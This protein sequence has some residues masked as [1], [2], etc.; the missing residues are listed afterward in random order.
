[1]TESIHVVPFSQ[2]IG[3]EKAIQVLKKAMARERMPHAYLFVGIHG[4]GKTTTALALAQAVNCDAPVEGEACDRCRLCRQILNGNFPDLTVINPD[5]RSIKIEQIREL[6]RAFSFKPVAGRYRVSIVR[7]AELM[8]EEAA[9]SFLKTLEEPP[10][11][12]I[13]ILDVK[14]P[15]DL[16]PT[17]VSR[18]QKVL[19][20][21]IPAP[22][23]EK[24]LQDHMDVDPL[25]ASVLARI[26]QG[27]LARALDL[28]DDEFME[29]RGYYVSQF[30]RLAT[31]SASELLE[32]ALMI[33]KKDNKRESDSSGGRGPAGLTSPLEIWGTCYR[34]LLF[35]KTGCGEDLLINVDFSDK[36]K[37]VSED[38]NMHSLVQCILLLNRAQKESARGRNPDLLMENTLLALN[39]LAG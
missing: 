13:L 8:T 28:N 15:R 37:K 9:N 11:G 20:R 33:T 18:C 26:S 27:S 14:E 31:L 35:L 10:E 23:I 38:Y 12:N 4:V 39:R 29:E 24:W 17:I 2:I 30:Q 6:N 25:R 5:G 21:P 16:L 19:F 32:M 3:Q 36:L 1:M 34:D 22:L 7:Q